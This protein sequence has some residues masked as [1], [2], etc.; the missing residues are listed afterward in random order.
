MAANSTKFK[1]HVHLS[2]EIPKIYAEIFQM[3]YYKHV[4]TPMA[5]GCK[6]SVDDESPDVDHKIYRSMI[7]S[8]LYLTTSRPNIMSASR[9]NI[10]SAIKLV[11]RYQSTP[12]QHHLLATKR[13]F[14]YLK[15][16]TNYG[17]WYP[18][19]KNF[20]FPIYTDA[21]WASCVD[22][23]KSTSGNAFYLGKSLVA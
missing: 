9:Q 19:G 10:M 21:N 23:R 16:N 12:M 14:R 2:R 18:K 17:L 5:I 22:D 13:I 11:A 8:L 7:G 15:G 4:S 20:T 6:L 1:R 3:E